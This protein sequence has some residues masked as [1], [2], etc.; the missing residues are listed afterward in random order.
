MQ[1]KKGLRLH[2]LLVPPPEQG[3]EVKARVQLAELPQHLRLVAPLERHHGSLYS[4]WVFL[5]SSSMYRSCR[6]MYRRARSWAGVILTGS[7][8]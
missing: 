5:A 1:S 2:E 4:S 6:C 7:A 3:V 8:G